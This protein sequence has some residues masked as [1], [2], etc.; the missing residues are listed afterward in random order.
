M[1]ENDDEDSLAFSESHAGDQDSSSAS[2]LAYSMESS[3]INSLAYSESTNRTG[4]PSTSSLNR[5]RSSKKKKKQ[6]VGMISELKT[7]L[8][9]KILLAS[10]L[11]EC[12]N[13]AHYNATDAD[14][15]TKQEVQVINV[16]Q[17]TDRD[18]DDDDYSN[19]DDFHSTVKGQDL[20]DFCSLAYSESTKRRQDIVSVKAAEQAWNELDELTRKMHLASSLEH[21]DRPSAIMMEHNVSESKPFSC[22]AGNDINKVAISDITAKLSSKIPSRLR[23]KLEAAKLREEAVTTSSLSASPVSHISSQDIATI[24]Q[25][26]DVPPLP[27]DD[28]P[29]ISKAKEIV[30]RRQKISQSLSSSP[31]HSKKS[32]DQNHDSDILMGNSRYRGSVEQV[33]MVTNSLK[34][35][36]PAIDALLTAAIK[37]DHQDGIA[38]RLERKPRDDAAS[39]VSSSAPIRFRRDMQFNRVSIFNEGKIGERGGD[40]VAKYQNNGRAAIKEQRGRKMSL[41][42]SGAEIVKYGEH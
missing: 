36:A 22:A 1:D 15:E 11:V 39:E 2:S 23:R 32:M 19:D 16:L 38:P 34:L 9:R 29:A 3:S 41:S 21:I 37:R 5:S 30:M 27:P 10:S 33:E 6:V 40:K 8:D 13:D 42:R 28:S 24:L 17:N 25:E 26:P 35:T 20:E 4:G 18:D 14:A 7:E 31:S 12:E